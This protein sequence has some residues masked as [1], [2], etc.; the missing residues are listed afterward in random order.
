MIFQEPLSSLNPLKRVG[1]QIEET[2]LTHQRPAPS[3]AEI[4]ARVLELLTQVGLPNPPQLANSYP[5]ELSGGQRQR[6]MIAMAMSNQ[7]ALLI[8]DEPTTALDVTTQRQILRLI[9]DL[10]A[11]PR[12]GRA[13]DHP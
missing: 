4:K 2:I 8:A 3:A 10:Q 7:P 1:E 12:H 9:D 5:F 6:V 13:A 11:R